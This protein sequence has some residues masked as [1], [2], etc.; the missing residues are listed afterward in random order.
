M[1]YYKKYF[2][3]VFQMSAMLA[4]IYEYVT[5]FLLTYKVLLQEILEF[6]GVSLFGSTLLLYP[7]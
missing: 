1:S 2:L 5:I 6:K 4:D 7:L 3:S